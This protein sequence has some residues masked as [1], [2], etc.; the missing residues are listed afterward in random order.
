MVTMKAGRQSEREESNEP[1]FVGRSPGA[2]RWWRFYPGISRKYIK[3]VSKSSCRRLSRAFWLGKIIR[4]LAGFDERRSRAR[5]IQLFAYL[6]TH[7][8]LA[9]NG[10]EDS[11]AQRGT[12]L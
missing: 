10:R 1:I 9:P 11:G 2:P 3:M 4:G 12:S 5:A 7:E 6:K 8:S